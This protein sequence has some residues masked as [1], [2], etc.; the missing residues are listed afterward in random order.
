MK[1][2]LANYFLK[3]YLEFIIDEDEDIYKNWAKYFVKGTMFVHNVYVWI[4][5]I[6]FFPLFIFYM[7][8]KKQYE[9]FEKDHQKILNIYNK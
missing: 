9:K 4:A 7:N 3:I 5:S 2:I 1:Q 6:I 8:F